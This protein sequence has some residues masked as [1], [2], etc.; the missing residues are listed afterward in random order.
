MSGANNAESALK[1]IQDITCLVRNFEFL[2]RQWTSF[3]SEL[4]KHLSEPSTNSEC[5]IMSTNTGLQSTFR[6]QLGTQLMTYS[7]L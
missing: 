5:N 4:L 7:V 3:N 1:L 6:H 2:L